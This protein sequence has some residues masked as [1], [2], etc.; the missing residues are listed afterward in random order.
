MAELKKEIQDIKEMLQPKEKKKGFKIPFS[1]RVNHVKAKDNYVTLVK[2]NEN[3]A[4]KFKRVQISEQ[5]FIEDYIP[6]LASAGYIFYYKKNPMI[7]LPSWSVEPFSA[8]KS[9]EESLNNGS[10]IKGYQLLM[11]RMKLSTLDNKV[12]IAGWFKYIA[13]AVAL[14]I[15]GYALLTGGG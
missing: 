6:R 2:L 4:V 11:N 15:I 14:G 9:Y 7:F 8:T 13:G 1:A 5:T 3:G 12:K 10:N